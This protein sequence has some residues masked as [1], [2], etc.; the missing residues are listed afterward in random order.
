MPSSQNRSLPHTFVQPNKV[1]EHCA[2]HRITQPH[3]RLLASIL[4]FCI[5]IISYFYELKSYESM[6]MKIS[7]ICNY[8]LV[9]FCIPNDPTMLAKVSISKI[10][11]V[12]V[13]YK[14]S[15]SAKR[16]L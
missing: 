6:S 12:S 4:Q 1:R 3:L 16:I 10:F 9:W 11:F 13:T 15:S 7:G 5:S 14:P 2:F 8:R